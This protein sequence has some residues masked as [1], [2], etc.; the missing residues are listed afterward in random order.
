MKKLLIG[1]GFFLSCASSSHAEF[2]WGGE[3]YTGWGNRGIS[4]GFYSVGNL[5]ATNSF[6]LDGLGTL[7]LKGQVNARSYQGKVGYVDDNIFEFSASLDM[8]EAGTLAI[9]NFN[10]INQNPWADGEIADRGSMNVFPDVPRQ[11]RHIQGNITGILIDGK[12]EAVE[13]DLAI[14][15]KNHVGALQYEIITDPFKSYGST[16]GSDAVTYDG[17]SIPVAEIHLT[18][19]TGFGIYDAS[20]ND[21]GDAEFFATY[22]I[23]DTGLVLIGSY[24]SNGDDRTKYNADITAVYNSKDTGLFK[25]VFLTY[26]QGTND[27]RKTVFSTNWGMDQWTA[28]LSIDSDGDMA[29]EAYYKFTDHVTGYIG[30][31]SGHGAYEGFDWNYIAPVTAPS[32]GPSWETGIKITF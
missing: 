23:A 6:E 32:R 9:T 22:P 4:P 26:T 17:A 7:D 14:K 2:K 27:L 19:P 5:H 10:T 24:A 13:R 11:F 30:W 12:V 18:L 25:G 1:A 28:S 3:I 21:V 29:A 20:F 8:G 16:W 15:Y 31:D